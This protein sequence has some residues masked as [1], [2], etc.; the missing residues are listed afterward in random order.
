MTTQ[1]IAQALWTRRQQ[2]P[3]VMQG[4]LQAQ[5][6]GEGFAEA[7]A[8]RWV[9]P[10]FDTG[11]LTV[12]LNAA[13]AQDLQQ[14]AVKTEAV[15]T[16]HDAAQA[17]ANRQ[18]ME[19][20][21]PGIGAGSGGSTMPNPPRPSTPTAPKMSQ[22]KSPQIGDDVMVAEQG[23]SF[24][25]K[26]QSVRPDGRYILSFGNTKPAK[27]RDY[28][29]NELRPVANANVSVGAGAPVPSNVA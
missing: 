16:A 29:A 26:V 23:K 8:N 6:G 19:L 25:G 28:T 14:A 20:N 7:V 15:D 22:T 13:Q 10:D 11:G 27:A 9:V 18:L 21:I 3:I 1:E 12:T 24:T 2:N 17:H 4:E 5:L